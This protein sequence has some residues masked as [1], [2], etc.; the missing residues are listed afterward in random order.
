[1]SLG[2]ANAAMLLALAGVS[3]PVIIHLLSRRRVPTVDWGAMMFLDPGKR[4]RTRL[5]LAELL[6]MLV[7]M[8]LLAAVALAAA[9][10]FLRPASATADGAGAPAP[11]P[12]SLAPSGSRR[13][14]VLILDASESM[15]LRSPD[16]ETPRSRS[17]A[18]AT[19]M[20]DRLATG[21]T[22]SLILAGPRPRA[23]TDAPTSDLPRVAQLLADLPAP[24]G[25]SDLPAALAESFRLLEKARHPAR[26]VVI[27]TDG[28]R[29]SWRPDEADRWAL[30]RDLHARLPVKPRLWAVRLP[31]EP[32]PEA[33]DGSVGP[34]EMARGLVAP[35]AVVEVSATITNAGPAP[36]SRSVSLLRDGQPEPGSDRPVGPIPPGGKTTATFRARLDTPGPHVLSVRLAPSESDPQPA[37]DESFRP[38][39]VATALPILLVDGEPGREPLTGETDF[40]RA[41]LAP[42]DDEAPQF[43]ATTVPPA[44]LTAEA[45]TK[46]R[47]LVLA[48]LP[49]LTP[50]QSSA[51][52]QFLADGGG[53]LFAPGDR[54]DAPAINADLFRDGS[55]WLPARL[56]EAVGDPS[57]RE[58]VAHP[59]PSTFAGP[60]LGPFS[61]GDAPPLG[62][63]SLFSYWTL[64]P[65]ESSAVLGRLD[66]G[67]PWLVE[68][69]YRRGRVAMLC[70]PIDAEGG[71]LPVNPDFVPLV[72]E[73][74]FHLADPSDRTSPVPLGSPL[75]FA[76]PSLPPGLETLTVSTPS[77][78]ARPATVER[79][80]PS[81]F[82]LLDDAPEPGLYR[83]SLP[84]PTGGSAFAVVL[85]DPIESSP[86]LLTPPEAES[87]SSGWPL[88]FDSGP[89]PADSLADRLLST[90]S[91]A[92]SP[93]PLWRG[94]I[95][96]ALA[97]LCAEVWF[98]RRL[99]RGAAA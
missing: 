39:E 58:A 25:G 27:L 96:F 9:R 3:L 11:D 23:L 77:G 85:A 6:L 89:S 80:G 98:T 38:V 83:L 95:A 43:V 97:G 37:N 86:S 81:A 12:A 48:N 18:W 52:G 57:G 31:V 36:L 5:R 34:L 16:G 14:L 70:G 69:P 59:D 62:R 17:L 75:R 82:A 28:H 22:A 60:I 73:L 45:L 68:R 93:R 24:S 54:S 65:A 40:L 56:G 2:L 78:L 99:A 41:A 10:P 51:V 35:G 84:S 1:M 53:V 4:A 49:R 91:P 55:S 33:A 79:S 61:R 44:G 63:A 21:D 76:L 92:R 46:T 64:E 32:G 26:D 30:L 67:S 8:A 94:L 15:G 20:L 42:R 71:T 47:V 88:V 19:R 87:L 66:T 13:D 74:I 90:T 7:R 72:H 50:D 29:S